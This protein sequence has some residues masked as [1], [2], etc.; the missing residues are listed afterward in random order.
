MLVTSN[1]LFPVD[2]LNISQAIGRTTS[3]LAPCPSIKMVKL[4]ILE[5][6]EVLISFNEKRVPGIRV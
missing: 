5:K 6:R 3:T 1:M 4:A 2:A